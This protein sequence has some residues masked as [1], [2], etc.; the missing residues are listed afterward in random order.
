MREGG[1]DQHD[2]DPCR[3]SRTAGRPASLKLAIRIVSSA[4]QS[5]ISDNTVSTRCIAAQIRSTET[6][7]VIAV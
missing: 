5:R 7:F 1:V 6:H 4:V 3:R 2:I